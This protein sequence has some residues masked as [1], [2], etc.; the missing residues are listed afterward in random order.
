MKSRSLP[1]L[2]IPSLK[3]RHSLKRD[4]CGVG[5]ENGQGMKWWEGVKRCAAEGPEFV[6]LQLLAAL[7]RLSRTS[8]EVPKLAVAN[9]KPEPYQAVTAWDRRFQTK[10]RTHFIANFPR[11]CSWKFLHSNLMICREAKAG[12]MSQRFFNLTF[13]FSG[14]IRCFHCNMSC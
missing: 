2:I 13:P 12:F 7:F 11:W 10:Y 14:N 6:P 5:L 9:G 8:W 1:F 4:K 3:S